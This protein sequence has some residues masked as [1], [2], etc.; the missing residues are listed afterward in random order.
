MSLK[1]VLNNSVILVAPWN[2]I[3]LWILSSVMVILAG[4]P[5][6]TLSLGRIGGV[7][8]L[9]ILLEGGGGWVSS[10]M[11]TGCV[12]GGSDIDGVDE[13]D[14]SSLITCTDF[15]ACGGNVLPNPPFVPS[16]NI[17]MG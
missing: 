7:R 14:V 8:A 6:R 17:E 5:D 13:S 1:H 16:S 10:S 11:R 15:L 3:P 2:P 9:V 4:S 12:K